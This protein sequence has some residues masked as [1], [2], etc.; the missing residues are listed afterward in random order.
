MTSPGASSVPAS[1]EPTMTLQAP[2]AIA[3]TTS[4]EYLIPP[5][6]MT[7]TPCRSAPRAQAPPAGAGPGVAVGGVEGDHVRARLEQ[8]RRPRLAVGA[9]PHR[10][11]AEQPAQPV[12]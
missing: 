10:R 4:P 8:R 5:S 7:G 2:A 9:H 11:A 3:F 6:E 1:R 12:L